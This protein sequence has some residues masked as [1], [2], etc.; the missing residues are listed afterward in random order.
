LRQFPFDEFEGASFL[1]NL[2]GSHRR[3]HGLVIVGPMIDVGSA[4]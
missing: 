1:C 2:D 3:R 4:A